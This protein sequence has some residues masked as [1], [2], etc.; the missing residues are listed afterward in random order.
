MQYDQ[1]YEEEKVSIQGGIGDGQGVEKGDEQK[2]DKGSEGRA[3][4]HGRRKR[5]KEKKRAHKNV[6]ITKLISPS[7]EA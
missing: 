6:S 4:R 3:L 5:K 1:Y 7:Y 2:V